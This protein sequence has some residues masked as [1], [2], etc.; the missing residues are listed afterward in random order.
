MLVSPEA[1]FQAAEDL[2]RRLAGLVELLAVHAAGAV[3]DDRDLAGGHLGRV[4]HDA[5]DR[6]V[7]HPRVA[8]DEVLAVAVHVNHEQSRVDPGQGRLQRTGIDA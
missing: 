3:D 5:D 7:V 2:K 4:R 6:F 8:V 1:L